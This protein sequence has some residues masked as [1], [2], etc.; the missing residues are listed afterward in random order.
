VLDAHGSSPHDRTPEAQLRRIKRFIIQNL[1]MRHLGPA[2]IARNFGISTRYLHKLFAGEKHTVTRLV[3]AERLDA[4]RRALSDPTYAEMSI[5]DIALHWGFYDL[6]HMSR[7]FR[8]TYR[9]TPRELRHSKSGSPR[10]RSHTS[11]RRGAAIK[12]YFHG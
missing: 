2:M 8:E 6:P 11:G 10:V 7:C 12:S 5:T 3:R 1:R 4:C 9:V